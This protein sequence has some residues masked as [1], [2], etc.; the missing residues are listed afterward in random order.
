MVTKDSIP[1][2]G[3]G[4]TADDVANFMRGNGVFN[5]NKIETNRK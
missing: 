3:R 5:L 4:G 1:D 2:R